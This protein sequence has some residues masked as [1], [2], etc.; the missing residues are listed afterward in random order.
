L[1]R[2]NYR[3][4]SKTDKKHYNFNTQINKYANAY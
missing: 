1:F 3:N 4:N 2:L